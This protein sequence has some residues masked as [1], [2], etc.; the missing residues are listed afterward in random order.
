M[1]GLSLLLLLAL[2]ATTH[3]APPPTPTAAIVTVPI[4]ARVARPALRRQARRRSPSTQPPAAAYPLRNVHMVALEVGSPPQRM[5]LELDTGS[6][7][8]GLLTPCSATSC[9]KR[10]LGG[11]AIEHQRVAIAA[12]VA[13]RGRGAPA[14]DPTA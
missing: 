4:I 11:A 10:V 5:A 9:G 12:R 7:D 1:M 2:L 6:S 3:A 14:T 13:V 8:T